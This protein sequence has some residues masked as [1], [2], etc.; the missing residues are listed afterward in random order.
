MFTHKENQKKVT[1]EE[2]QN[3]VNSAENT[4]VNNGQLKT[5]WL[6]KG[7]KSIIPS[8]PHKLTGYKPIENPFNEG[9]RKW[10]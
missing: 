3:K 4:L 8:K 2:M 10:W 9:K 6:E 7:T 1:K 5:G